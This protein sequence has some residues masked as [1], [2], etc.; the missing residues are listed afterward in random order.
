MSDRPLNRQMLEKAFERMG[1]ILARKK[2]F[3]EIAVY[4]GTAVMLQLENRENTADVDCV[5][6]VGHDPIMDAGREVGRQLGLGTSWLNEQVSIY[7]SPKAG[8]NDHLPYGTYP[9]NGRPH[10]NV[11]LAKPEYLVAMKVES[12]KR[13][14]SRDIDDLA[15]LAAS[16]GLKTSDDIFRTH[17]LFFGPD[18]ITVAMKQAVAGIAQ[19]LSNGLSNDAGNTPNKPK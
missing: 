9:L 7:R 19:N 1:A 14:Q 18:R 6:N 16:L 12:L 17:A 13:A 4:G 8:E 11:I 5:V 15:K 3:G 2:I 10:L